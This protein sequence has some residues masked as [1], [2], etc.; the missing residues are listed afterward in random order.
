MTHTDTTV[1][2]HTRFH[3]YVVGKRKSLILYGKI[4]FLWPRLV[5]YLRSIT[6]H[7]GLIAH[8]LGTWARA[9]LGTRP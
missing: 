1:P 4:Q 7:D 9:F 6:E 3:L 8:S 2:A 5:R